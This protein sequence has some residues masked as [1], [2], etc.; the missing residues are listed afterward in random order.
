MAG[1]GRRTA[2]IVAILAIALAVRLAAGVWWQSRVP[3]GKLFAFGDS[4]SYW[5]LAQT[6]ARG[7]PY[8]FG[9]PD[10]KIFRT[11]GYPALL[12]A[13]MVVLNDD[14]PSVYWARGLSAVCGVLSVAGVMTLAWQLFGRR[15]ALVAGAVAALHPEAISL[16]VF[17]LSEAPFCPLMLAHLALW[18]AAWRRYNETQSGEDIVENERT[19]PW[20]PWALA[21]GVAGG[22]ATLMRPSWLLFTPY[23]SLLFIALDRRRA[24][25][26][27]IAIVMGL[28]IAVTLA[29]WWYR[30]YQI[31]GRFVLTTLQVG[32]SLYDGL[33][34]AATGASDMRFVARF[35][36][37][38]RAADQAAR[39]D[40]TTATTATKSAPPPTTPLHGT[41]E[42][43]L[44]RRMRDAAVAWAKAN[45]AA[46]A[47]LTLVKFSRIW[48]PL[49]NASELGSRT[50]RLAIA[51]G[52]LPL[53]I[54]VGL[55][56]WRFRGRA[57]ELALLLLPAVYFT[58]LH[59]IFVSSIRYRQ[60]A[61]LPWMALA[62]GWL[63]ATFLP[64]DDKE[65]A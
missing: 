50:T 54:A 16:S 23:A 22:A 63:V 10:L 55:A 33:S 61:L 7:E 3:T 45:P 58:N 31:T 36:E 46:V 65:D 4:E 13:L 12:A 11:P 34:P 30:N 49:P 37:E 59:V 5:F 53:L 52:Y 26:A 42:E 40:A 28:G 27:R 60:P 56:S 43:R 21:A 35:E 24:A 25:H 39:A 18:L 19:A 2:W 62:A 44:D 9:S 41:F 1:Q 64:R 32:A 48:N 15:A 57:L 29:P 8:Q 51:A 14:N 38:Q 20:G 47:R 6:I 17:V